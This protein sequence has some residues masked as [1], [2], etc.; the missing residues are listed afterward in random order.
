MILTFTALTQTQ[1][2]RDYSAYIEEKVNAWNK[3]KID[4]MGK[5][6][7]M[8]E[9]FQKSPLDDVLL[10]RIEILQKLLSV[11]LQCSVPF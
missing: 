11:L 1:N 5:K 4:F 9:M 7:D 10:E 3:L 8:I 2:L 6:K